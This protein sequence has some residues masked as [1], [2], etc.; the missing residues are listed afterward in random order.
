MPIICVVKSLYWHGQEIFLFSKMSRPA[1][2]FTQPPL[3][4]MSGLFHSGKVARMWSWSLIPSVKVKNEWS[5]ALHINPSGP[6]LSAQ[7]T[8]HKQS[9]SKQSLYRPG[10]ALRVPGAWG[11][12]DF[13]TVTTCRWYGCQLYAPATFTWQEIFLVL[14]SVG[15][16][17]DLRARMRPDGLCQQKFQRHC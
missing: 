9:K 17:V 4:W 1:L 7:C 11:S 5:L 12:L 3:Q 15:G 14:I 10:E 2:G 16:W 8:L 6:D 13:K